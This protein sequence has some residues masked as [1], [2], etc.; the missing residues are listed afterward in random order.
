[1]IRADMIRAD[2]IRADMIPHTITI[3]N[4]S[5]FLTCPMQGW[6][7]IIGTMTKDWDNSPKSGSI[8]AEPFTMDNLTGASVLKNVMDRLLLTFQPPAIA[9]SD[10]I[11]NIVR[12]VVVNE[13]IAGQ[14]PSGWYLQQVENQL[15]DLIDGIHAKMVKN[16]IFTEGSVFHKLRFGHGASSGQAVKPVAPIRVSLKAPDG[17]LVSEHTPTTIEIIGESGVTDHE[18]LT[19]FAFSSSEGAKYYLKPYLDCLCHAASLPAGTPARTYTIC[20][21]NK[22][23]INVNSFTID[24]PQEAL[25]RLST[26]VSHLVFKSHDYQLTFAAL[27]DNA[28]SPESLLTKLSRDKYPERSPVWRWEQYPVATQTQIDAMIETCYRHILEVLA[29]GGK[30]Q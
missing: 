2:M 17:I 3:K 14:L 9:S 18:K 5:D 29:S 26:M 12:E 23:G 10:K 28:T 24:T 22:K 1:M 21:A 20:Y 11:R 27:A 16:D 13:S 19:F 6:A 8:D 25:N 4:L 15:V 7:R 30:D